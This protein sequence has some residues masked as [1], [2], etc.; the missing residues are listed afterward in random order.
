MPTLEE[1]EAAR[2]PKGGWTKAQLAAWGVPWPPQKGWRERLA[3]GEA[4]PTEQFEP[5]PV[6][7][8]ISAH[9]LLIKVVTAVVGAG[10]ASDLYEFPDVL[11]Y[12]GA[13]IPD[14]SEVADHHPRST[15]AR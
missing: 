8:D 14:P 11:A 1:I 6:R 15:E 13:R 7:P 2:T 9:D 4:F 3:A 12:F 5:S 10:H